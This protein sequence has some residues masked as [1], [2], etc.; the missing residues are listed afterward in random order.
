MKFIRQDLLTLLISLFIL[1]G[2]SNP[3]GVGLEVDPE[4]AISG[5]LV[6]S[7]T[8]YS[9]TL[10][11]D[12]LITTSMSRYPLG[13]MRDPIFGTTE[14][15]LAMTVSLPEGNLS[16]GT[17]PVLDSAVL[18]LK[19]ADFYGDSTGTS[20]QLDVHQLE[21]PLLSSV[22][23]YN[24]TGHSFN[25][26]VLGSKRI[27]RVFLKDS[28]TVQNIVKGQADGQ[29]K[30]PAQIRIPLDPAFITANVLNAGANALATT[31]AFNNFFKGLY[32]TVNKQQTTGPGGVMYFDLATE[33]SS[34]LQLY[35]KT[36]SGSTVDTTSRTL[37][38][39]HGSSPVAANFFHNYAGT[40]V[41]AQLNSTHQVASN[42]Y[43]QGLAGLKTKVTFPFLT[44]LKSLGNVTVNKAELVVDVQGGEVPFTPLPR[45][46]MYRTDIAGQK[47]LLPDVS[48]FDFRNITD[49]EF[50]GYYNP[51]R[52]RYVFAITSY[53]QDIINGKLK[54]FDA[55]LAPADI[56]AD[57]GAATNPTGLVAGRSVLGGF[58]NP[59]VK[60]KLNIFYTSANN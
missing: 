12:S 53:V 55:F 37:N 46:F 3:E 18:V 43:V 34:G 47:Q 52:K 33:G 7:S 31:S 1:S 40:P 35:Y 24:T 59:T 21:L 44:N 19:Y 41:E 38:I 10:R 2:C 51:N 39:A 36:T 8:I 60:M 29:K 54:Q 16:F 26:Q 56:L 13:F 28:V 25:T 30:V 17:S 32:V 48:D 50:G 20:Y 14:A 15:N 4:Y 6:D 11:E 58:G 27:N 5:T 22:T 45:L 42:T 49:V 23:Y 57:K 9:S